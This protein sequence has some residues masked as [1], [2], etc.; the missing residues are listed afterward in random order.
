MPR[1]SRVWW[2]LDLDLHGHVYRVAS[3]AVDVTSGADTLRYHGGLVDASV[4]D[5]GAAVTVAWEPPGGWAGLVERGAVLSGASLSLRL[6]REGDSYEEARLVAY[7]QAGEPEY[8][9]LGEGLTLSISRDWW[10]GAGLTVPPATAKVDATTW[11]HPASGGSVPDSALEVAYPIPIGHPGRVEFGAG[12]TYAALVIARV[13]TGVWTPAGSPAVFAQMPAAL[14]GAWYDDAVL[15]I[16]W[17]PVEATTVVVY[18]ATDN[19]SW[20]ASTYL[21]Q[22]ESGQDVTVVDFGDAVTTSWVIAYPDPE[23]EYWVDWTEGGGILCDR[24]DEALRGAGDVVDWMLRRRGAIARYDAGRQA[25]WGALLNAWQIDAYVSEAVQPDEW[26]GQVLGQAMPLF[27]ALGP[28]GD[29]YGLWRYFA[30]DAD[31]VA[32]FDVGRNASRVGRARVQDRDLANTITLRYG[33]QRGAFHSVLLSWSATDP[34]E[35]YLLALESRRLFGERTL[36]VEVPCIMV[37][38]AAHM[39]MLY[40]LGARALPHTAVDIDVSLW[41]AAWLTRGDVV[42]LGDDSLGWADRR[43]ALV[44]DVPLSMGGLVT[45]P[46]LV[47]N[48]LLRSLRAT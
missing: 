48:P 36:E 8:G 43:V 45:L 2:L 42:L 1:S 6:L 22:D 12:T 31:A 29:F 7:G 32:V 28:D 34:A 44:L 4:S 33:L 38:G 24:S 47:L 3:E 41:E 18:D 17:G 21:D 37:A 13:T 23:H 10:A 20:V 16:A 11:P 15:V 35:A 30:T 39:S 9:G 19:L 5:D 26:V 14:A 25:A 40:L 46:L 27:S